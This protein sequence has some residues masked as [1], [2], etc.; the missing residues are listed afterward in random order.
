MQKLG[1]PYCCKTTFWRSCSRIKS[2][3]PPKLQSSY[4]P[5][6]F[7]KLFFWNKTEITF[8][9]VCFWQPQKKLSPSLCN[10][11]NLVWWGVNQLHY[12]FFC[13]SWALFF[14]LL[15]LFTF[16]GHAKKE[17][18]LQHF[19][20]SGKS[21]CRFFCQSFSCTNYETPPQKKTQKRK[22]MIIVGQLICIFAKT[23]DMAMH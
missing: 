16:V 7:K 3:P 23:V 15:P 5:L 11:R 14:F 20:T 18:N 4:C 1:A 19:E 9:L 22:T 21:G 8:R 2:S 13:L 17:G 6:V 12:A 10:W